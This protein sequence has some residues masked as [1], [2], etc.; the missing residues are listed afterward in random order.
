MSYV[1]M[2]LTSIIG[3]GHTK[4][5]LLQ[6]FKTCLNYWGMSCH[7]KQPIALTFLVRFPP[8][9]NNIVAIA[10]L[11]CN[12]GSTVSLWKLTLLITMGGKSLVI[13]PDVQILYRLLG[14]K[15]LKTAQIYII[16]KPTKSI[17]RLDFICLFYCICKFISPEVWK[18]VDLKQVSFNAVHL[19]FLRTLL[20][21]WRTYS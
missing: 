18:T 11:T 9:H 20:C 21:G 6:D 14:E 7:E 8:S 1:P 13:S 2:Q 16:N 12:S 17:L 5:S 15:Q 3:W 19:N 10:Q 4:R